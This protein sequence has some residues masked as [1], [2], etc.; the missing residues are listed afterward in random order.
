VH[1]DLSLGNIL[2]CDGHAK[3]SDLEYAKR[4]GDLKSH[5]MRTASESPITL[6]GESLIGQG[7]M[8]FMSIEVAARNFL[9]FPSDPGLSLT[10]LDGFVSAMEQDGGTA[11]SNVPFSHNHLHDLESLWWV[12][13]WVVFHNHFSDGA[14]SFTLQDA[15]AQCKLARTLFPLV[16][17]SS[18]RRQSF[19]TPGSF[20][21]TCDALSRNKKAICVRLDGLRRLLINHYSAVEAGYPVS[22]DPN[23]SS[24]EIYDGFT[25]TFSTL[26]SMSGDLALYFIPDIYA[27]LLK[28]EK[29][30]KGENSKRARSESTKDRGVAQKN[31]RT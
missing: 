28:D 10:E 11:Q 29:M 31:Q 19:Q 8:H 13:V 14:P 1:R 22:V 9:F 24:D 4:V 20:K 21:H 12:A 3:L 2:S 6:C 16:L 15:E 30:L 5:E 17:E 27:N 18:A 26:Q 23:S 25:R 7:T